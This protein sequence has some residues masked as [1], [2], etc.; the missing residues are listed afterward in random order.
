M[1]SRRIP[2]WLPAISLLA[3]AFPWAGCQTESPIEQEMWRVNSVLEQA[4]GDALQE[5]MD[6]AYAKSQELLVKVRG[7]REVALRH[8]EEVDSLQSKIAILSRSKDLFAVEF[9]KMEARQR[10]YI[11]KAEDLRQRVTL[12]GEDLEKLKATLGGG[13]DAVTEELRLL[14]E[15]AGEDG[16]ALEA[17]MAESKQLAEKKAAAIAE[18]ET[19]RKGAGDA[20]SALEQLRTALAEKD[21]LVKKIAAARDDS[22]KLAAE[23]T[24]LEARKTADEAEVKT[25]RERI[26]A[27]RGEKGDVNKQMETLL[28]QEGGVSK[29]LDEVRGRLKALQEKK[30]ATDA[31]HAKLQEELK[32]VTENIQLLKT[33]RV[34]LVAETEE[35]RKQSTEMI[36]L[37]ATLE[38]QVEEIK[39]EIDRLQ[40]EIDELKKKKEE[41]SVERDTLKSE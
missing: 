11:K 35:I 1:S 34:D 5:R 18:T 8:G 32:P 23:R 29:E 19:L 39:A 6:E 10:A 4:R 40:K 13:P 22:A 2:S 9:E 24:E 37:K 3:L 31:E 25:L 27:L 16:K 12:A 36:E 14:R 38:A 26:A 33:M 21:E 41:K 30:L 28:A 20:Q 17:A 15:A 7:Y